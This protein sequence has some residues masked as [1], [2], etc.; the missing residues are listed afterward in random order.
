MTSFV[1]IFSGLKT[2]CVVRL[3][4]FVLSVLSTLE[5][6]GLHETPDLCPII[7]CSSGSS[8]ARFQ[9]LRPVLVL[10]RISKVAYMLDLP[11]GST[12]HPIFHVSQLKRSPGSNSVSTTILSELAMFQ[13]PKCI[14]QRRWTSSDNPVKQVFINGPTCRHPWLPRSLLLISGS[15]FH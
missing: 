10:E 7:S 9:V 15:N 3:I 1:C 6:C 11:S 13:V 5:I 14:L 12:V 2:E 8:Q 4:T